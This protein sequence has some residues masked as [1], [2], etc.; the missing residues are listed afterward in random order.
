M[1]TI[2]GQPRIMRSTIC[3]KKILSYIKIS[4]PNPLR[5]QNSQSINSAENNL[6]IYR[7]EL[8][9]EVSFSSQTKYTEGK[10]EY[11]YELA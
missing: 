2:L 7:D 4:N 8:A 10:Y 6:M 11:Y 9:L 1:W 5:R 3:I